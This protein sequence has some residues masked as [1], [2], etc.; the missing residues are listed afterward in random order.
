MYHASTSNGENRAIK[1]YKTSI[2]MFKDRDKYVSGEFRWVG[3]LLGFTGEEGLFERWWNDQCWYDTDWI[4]L[5]FYMYFFKISSWILQRQPKKNGEDMGWKRNEEFNKVILPVFISACEGN[6]KVT[7][8]TL[9]LLECG[10]Y[11]PSWSLEYSEVSYASMSEGRG[12]KTVKILLCLAV[13]T[14]SSSVSELW[15]DWKVRKG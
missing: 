11:C 1:I 3:V 6:W 12:R 8:Y 10:C 5:V 9:L 14:R 2:L 13:H 15:F 7:G 4:P